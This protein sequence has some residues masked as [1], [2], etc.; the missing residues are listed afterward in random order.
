MKKIAKN[1]LQNAHTYESYRQL[2]DTLFTQNKTTGDDHSEAMLAYTKL[3][4]ARMNKWDK[5]TR[6]TPETLQNLSKI[7]RPLTWLVIT[8]GWCGD[9][10]Q[11]VP[12][13]H[14]M[15]LEN[16][17]ITLRF[18][19][20]DAH[21]DII[22]AF[23]TNSGRSIPKVIILDTET[24]EVLNSW[25]PRPTEM[26]AMMMGV[27]AKSATIADAA[28]KK[29]LSQEAAQQLHLWYAKDKAKTTQQEFL[30]GV[31]SQIT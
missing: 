8:E 12:V 13:L 3:N 1:I 17:N 26:Q 11:I 16:D 23:L 14:K 29:T 10:A 24:S 9:A 18:I 20:R 21:P 30:A 25:G 5:R 4:L 31:G 27:K 19:L 15:A 6:L 22:D 2:I 28:K 7:Q